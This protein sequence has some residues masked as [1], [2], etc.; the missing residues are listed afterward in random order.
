MMIRR[1]RCY[2]VSH[3]DNMMYFVAVEALRTLCTY[4][5]A[6]IEAQLH[7]RP[8]FTGIAASTSSLAAGSHLPQIE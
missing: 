4:I 5:F 8:L 2:K 7:L 1:L 3:H 6:W